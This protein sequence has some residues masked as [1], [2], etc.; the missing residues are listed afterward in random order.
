MLAAAGAAATTLTFD[1][2]ACGG[3]CNNGN[4]ISQA[5]GDVTGQ[6]DVTYSAGTS[7]V[8]FWG[9]GYSGLTNVAYGGTGAEIFLQPIGGATVTLLGLDLGSFG[10]ASRNSQVTILAGD[11]TPLFSS[12]TVSVAV[13]PV[14]F[15]FNLS[16]PSG[17]RVQF[18]P[19]SFNV[20]IDNIE[21][22][23]VA[24]VPE[25]GAGVLVAAGL[26]LIGLATRRHSPR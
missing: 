16:H 25:P 2:N 7:V 6:L 9:T 1:G 8:Q 15:A 11:G 19:D 26:G 17:I 21:F 22:N 12:G 24:G 13:T 20:A 18:G 3:G 4:P 14:H 5:Y 10:G 23:L